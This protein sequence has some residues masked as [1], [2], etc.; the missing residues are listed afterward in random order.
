LTRVSSGGIVGLA[1]A[2]LPTGY[3]ARNGYIIG[4]GVSATGA[5]LASMSFTGVNMTGI[6]LSAATLTNATLTGATLT[7]ANLTNAILTNAITG[8]GIIG[9]VGAT[10]ATLPAGYVAR[11]VNTD[12]NGFIIG[13]RVSLQNAVLTTGGGIDLSGVA[14]TS[15]NFTGANLTNA[16]LTNA[17]ISGAIFTNTTLT[18][19][20]S[21]GLIGAATATLRTG[22]VVRYTGGGGAGTGSGFLIGAGVSLSGADLSAV[23]MSGI[24]LTSTDFTGANLTNAIMRNA[25]LTTANL[26][27]A[28]ITGILTG[29]IVG[30]TTATLPSASYVA[31]GG[32][33]SVGWIVGPNVKL[34][35]ANLSNTDLTDTTITGCDISGAN[36][37]GATIT[38]M[39]SGGLLYGGGGTPA[40]ANVT[41]PNASTSVRGASGNGY[42]VGPGVSLVGANLAGIDLSG[43]T[44]TSADIDGTVFTTTTNLT[45]I[46]TGELRNSGL[47]TFPA[48]P[49]QSTAY[50]TRNGFIVGP[51]V[52]LLSADL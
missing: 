38:G 10:A 9:L 20:R 16:I 45:N 14:L 22:Y 7:S 51:G 12:T 35:G 36:F 18:G 49:P 43:A 8:G 37:S 50:F 11:I 46:T 29:H 39:R 25:T 44:F 30:L 47:A 52:R 42:I 5:A 26:S 28:N 32:G 2:T 19:V 4:P 23:D 48:T 1:T 33:G 24:V 3:V 13:P 40:T 34:V 41:L 21:G 31:R 6:D 17:D 27:G 15:A